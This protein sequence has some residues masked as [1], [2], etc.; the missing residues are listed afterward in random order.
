MK[1]FVL[2]F[3]GA[4]DE[5]KPGCLE[6]DIHQDSVQSI[7]HVEMERG[8]LKRLIRR[9]PGRS[10]LTAPL[11]EA[12]VEKQKI[13]AQ[14]KPRDIEQLLRNMRDLTVIQDDPG[15]L[16]AAVQTRVSENERDYDHFYIPR[17]GLIFEDE[18][19]LGLLDI[20]PFSIY[21]FIS[22]EFRFK[23]GARCFLVYQEGRRYHLFWGEGLEA[24][25]LRVVEEGSFDEVMKKIQVMSEY[26]ASEFRYIVCASKDEPE[27][28]SLY[29][30]LGWQYLSFSELSQVVQENT[31]Y[32]PLIAAAVSKSRGRAKAL[33][34]V[35][36]KGLNHQ[37]LR[38]SVRGLSITVS[39]FLLLTGALLGFWDFRARDLTRR[40]QEAFH[41]EFYDVFS[42]KTPM[43]N[44]VEQLRAQIEDK[45]SGGPAVGL[46]GSHQISRIIYEVQR[47]MPP[48]VKVYEI[49]LRDQKMVIE[50]ESPS[51][52]AL[53]LWREQ[54]ETPLECRVAIELVTQ[55]QF[56]M[57]IDVKRS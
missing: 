44:P 48:Q 55:G 20:L 38:R 53:Q 8:E 5:S 23:E 27:K 30:V 19:S 1:Y 52:N 11:S 42:Q 31:A 13:P 29:A 3:T 12:Y 18:W 57:V 50:G 37:V 22:S 24:Q 46:T 26:Q 7:R 54:L 51:E 39:L 14:C 28:T 47:S 6:I 35:S 43:I 17:G 10:I 2:F 49:A 9:N 21:E 41:A 16:H 25:G 4:K 32:F 34:P 36:H 15:Y 33:E 40:Y 56:R 45:K